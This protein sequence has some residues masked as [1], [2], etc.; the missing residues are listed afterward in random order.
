VNRCALR[1]RTDSCICNVAN[2]SSRSRPFVAQL[3]A[4]DFSLDDEVWLEPTPGHTP[5][6]VCVH[7]ASQGAHAVVTG[8]C[9]HSPVQCVEPGWIMRADFDPALARAT[10]QGFL[11]RYCNSSAM[12]GATH[13]PEPSAGRIIQRDDAFW[14]DYDTT[15]S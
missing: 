13:F 5:G 14:F 15:E 1:L 3:V 6:H 12:V 10:R 9:I 4:S 11:E 8:D 7:L 2:T